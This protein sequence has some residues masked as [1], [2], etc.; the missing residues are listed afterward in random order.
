MEALD[1]VKVALLRLHS[2]KYNITVSVFLPPHPTLSL[3]VVSWHW[4]GDNM[5][6]IQEKGSQTV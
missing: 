1:G 2:S 4:Q 3:A 6:N 5:K